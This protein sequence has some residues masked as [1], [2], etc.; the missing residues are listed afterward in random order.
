MEYRII[1]KTKNAEDLC[2]KQTSREA[3]V[4]TDTRLEHFTPL[5]KG[6]LVFISHRIYKLLQLLSIPPWNILKASHLSL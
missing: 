3:A 4:T 6:I 5:I 1:T 2:L